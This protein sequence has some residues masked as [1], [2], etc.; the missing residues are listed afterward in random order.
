MSYTV[1]QYIEHRMSINS[2]D[3]VVTTFPIPPSTNNDNC[4]NG[5]K[6]LTRHSINGSP[7][8]RQVWEC[9][10]GFFIFEYIPTEST[11]ALLTETVIIY[12]SS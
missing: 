7:L 8:S 9:Q 3:C 2:I 10:E 12:Y 11:L 5:N 6:P 4:H 1:V